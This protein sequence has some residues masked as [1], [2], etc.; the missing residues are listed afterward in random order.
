MLGLLAAVATIAQMI[1]LSKAVDRVFLKGADLGE[2][3]ALLLLLLGASSLRSGL[4]WAR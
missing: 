2:V 3:N 1:F 4:L